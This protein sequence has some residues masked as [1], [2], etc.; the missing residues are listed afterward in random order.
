MESPSYG[1]VGEARN[2]QHPETTVGTSRPE[3]FSDGIMA[4]IITITAL[5]LKAPL[6]V[7]F[8]VSRQR[9]TMSGPNSGI[10]LGTWLGCCAHNAGGPQCSEALPGR[11][12]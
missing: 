11:L 8:T 4:V 2:P 10:F 7:S 12:V 9:R 5:S 1:R 6:S 3:A